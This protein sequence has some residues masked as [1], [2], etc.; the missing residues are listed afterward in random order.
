M[1][2]KALQEKILEFFFLYTLRKAFWMR[3]LTHGRTQSR[4]FFTKS[5]HFYQ[6]SKKDI[7]ELPFHSAS[8]TP[9]M[10]WFCLEN[11]SAHRSSLVFS[12]KNSV[13]VKKH[14]LPL[15]KS[16]NNIVMQ[17]KIILKIFGLFRVFW[18]LKAVFYS[19]RIVS[20]NKK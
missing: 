20:M 3:N 2:E 11:V 1:K 18:N 14:V 12:F 5:E 13:F 9:E 8:C 6:F 16:K 7:G 10:L 4:H 17:Q 15:F 19:R